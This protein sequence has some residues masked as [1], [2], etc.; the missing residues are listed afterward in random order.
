MRVPGIYRYS[1]GVL[2]QVR[3]TTLKL[4]KINFIILIFFLMFIKLL[5]FE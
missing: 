4:A 5:K 1:L 3:T 2:P